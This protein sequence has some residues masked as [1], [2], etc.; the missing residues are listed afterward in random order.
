MAS[1]QW[2]VLVLL[3]LCVQRSIAS[4]H[5]HIHPRVVVANETRV[6]A[7]A[8]AS[9]PPLACGASFRPNAL[10]TACPSVCG[11]GNFCVYYAQSDVSP[12]TPRAGSTCFDGDAC[13]FECLAT[14]GS[15][16]TWYLTLFNSDEVFASLDAENSALAVP[17][18]LVNASVVA[19]VGDFAQS[20]TLYALC[21]DGLV[22]WSVN[23]IVT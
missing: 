4:V 9:L 21:V 6:T 14:W 12:C 8:S 19:Q 16:D 22:G 13:T 7:S 23:V 3:A 10:S 11:V 1:L 18:V 17:S 2:L 5:V 15:T 20:G